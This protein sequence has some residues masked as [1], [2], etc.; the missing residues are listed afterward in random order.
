MPS[1]APPEVLDGE[2]RLIFAHDRTRQIIH[3]SWPETAHTAI[4]RQGERV[5]VALSEGR[6]G[7]E[8]NSW[9]IEESDSILL[10]VKEV[11]YSYN[12]VNFQSKEEDI[13]VN[14]LLTDIWVYCEPLV[15][16]EEAK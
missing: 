16:I 11:E 14:R 13:D 2:T 10:L 7:E 8:S 4:P 12:Y 6:R 1:E 15:D 3:Q 9:E 5:T